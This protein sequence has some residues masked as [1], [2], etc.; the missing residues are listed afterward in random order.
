MTIEQMKAFQRVLARMGFE[1]ECSVMSDDKS[2]SGVFYRHKD[3][4]EASLRQGRAWLGPDEL[5][6]EGGRILVAGRE[7]T[8]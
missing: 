6:I 3:G 4:R 5:T 2:K 1:Q 7:V 8:P